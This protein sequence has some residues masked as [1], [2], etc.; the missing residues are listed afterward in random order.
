MIFQATPLPGL[1]EVAATPHRDD[2]GTFARAWCAAAFQ[3]AGLGF[4]PAQTSLSTN[5]TAFTLRGL[6]YQSPPHAETKLVR[7]VAGRAFDVAVDLR[8]GATYGRWHGV[9]LSADRANA[10]FIPE[11]FAH[12]F[13]TLEPGTVL[14]YHISP[15]HVP[16]QGRGLRWDDPDIGIDWP[17]SPALMSEADRALPL[18]AAI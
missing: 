2:R 16:G 9:E 1:V 11:G 4:T 18:L 15:A 12:G 7:A 8:P 13:L 17:A 14:L 5:P 3:D 10:L 6:H